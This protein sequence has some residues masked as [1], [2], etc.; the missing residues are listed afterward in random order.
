VLNEPS[1]KF[2][3]AV[4]QSY[5]KFVN[6]SY[7][8]QVYEPKDQQEIE[9]RTSEY[10]GKG[11]NH[12]PGL[13]FAIN[14]DSAMLQTYAAGASDSGGIGAWSQLAINGSTVTRPKVVVLPFKDGASLMIT[15]VTPAKAPPGAGAV[16]YTIGTFTGGA[17]AEITELGSGSY[18]L[19]APLE[20]LSVVPDADD[21]EQT[22][23]LSLSNG[24]LNLLRVSSD[25]R[26]LDVRG[27]ITAANLSIPGDS[28]STACACTCPRELGP[29]RLDGA[30]CFAQLAAT[31]SS[32]DLRMWLIADSSASVLAQQALP[33]APPPK[34]AAVSGSVVSLGINIGSRVPLKSPH[35][36]VSWC[37]KKRVFM[38]IAAWE[39]AGGWEFRTGAS[40]GPVAVGVA[41]HLS[42]VALDGTAG[43]ASAVT[44]GV[45]MLVH[46]DGFCQNNEAQNKNAKISVCDLP[47]KG[48]AK[49]TKEVLVYSYAWRRDF[50]VKLKAGGMMS[51]CDERVMHG[52]YSRG[53][54]PTAA[55]FASPG[56]SR[57][58]ER[59][60]GW[61]IAAVHEGAGKS[62][63]DAGMCG[64]A[65]PAPGAAVL[66]GW[67]PAT[68]EMH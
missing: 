44:E 61:G 41:P 38:A 65:A 10:T 53:S 19:T 9:T 4:K 31:P 8:Y 45:L 5:G 18:V 42:F 55:L 16:T 6:S 13:R 30:L 1:A 43:N 36:A 51:A 67:T 49:S 3:S 40:S 68:V 59:P 64:A 33:Q 25:G 27:N 22:L 39:S 23:A 26:S 56:R 17:G 52:A 15:I 50:E 54:R 11:L 14:I 46:G 58:G 28:Y 35:V 7:T 20:A 12:A 63:L 24:E 34:G 60:D 37:F 2:N 62:A 66:A 32:L 29:G 48:N 57:L 21:G 47:S